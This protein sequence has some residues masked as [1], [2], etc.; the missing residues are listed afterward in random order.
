M[1]GSVFSSPSLVVYLPFVSYDSSAVAHAHRRAMM[2]FSTR[3][4][5]IPPFI[6]VPGR[7][8]QM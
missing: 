1:Q 6:D 7:R 8:S 3:P 2:F 5:T 4:D